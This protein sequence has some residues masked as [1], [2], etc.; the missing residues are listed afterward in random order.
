MENNQTDLTLQ[1]VMFLGQRLTAL[2]EKVGEIHQVVLAQRVQKEWYTTAE[3]AEALGKKQF[4]IQEKWC[5]L[6]GS[7]A[8]K[9]PT[10]ASG[11]SLDTNFGGWSA[12]VR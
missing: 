1:A 5:N 4:T 9:T 11:A 3:L 10:L 6:V 2:E 12:A 8:R 7:N